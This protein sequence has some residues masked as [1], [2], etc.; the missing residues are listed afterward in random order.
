MKIRILALVWAVLFGI[1][2][3][4]ENTVTEPEIEEAQEVLIV[5]EDLEAVYS[6]SYDPV[7]QQLNTQNLSST[8]QLPV[9]YLIQ[10]N[11]GNEFSFFSFESGRFSLFRQNMV[12]SDFGSWPGFYQ[13]TSERSIIWGA[14]VGE[15]IFLSYFSPVGSRNLSLLHL[16]LEG[17]IQNEVQIEFGAERVY[18]PLLKEGHLL[19]GYESSSGTYKIAVYEVDDFRWIG[20]LDLT[21]AGEPA[22]FIDEGRLVILRNSSGQTPEI[23]VYELNS[24][25]LLFS[26]SSELNQFFTPGPMQGRLV[27]NNLHYY[28]TYAQPS[29]IIDGPA[30]YSLDR[31]TNKLF[32]LNSIRQDLENER[33]LQ[34]L[35]TAKGLGTTNP[36][37]FFLG[38]G[39]QTM[40]NSIEGGLLI[41]DSR[42][43]ILEQ[44]DL[45]Y[46]PTGLISRVSD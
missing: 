5:G 27:G 11:Y 42:G 43:N 15:S 9:D 10:R 25:E 7:T 32:D 46:I 22:Y 18:P 34:L 35:F 20:T 45:P 41:L 44:V 28:F 2:C 12:S 8:I 23:L 24:L 21:E 26:E 29:A 36:P 33:G 4:T 17:E 16:S 38:Y 3:S 39:F 40:D 30:E 19:V 13:N 6:S 1:S 31:R 37:Q 14:D